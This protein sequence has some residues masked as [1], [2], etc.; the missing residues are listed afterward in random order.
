MKL[1]AF[2]TNYLQLTLEIDK[3]VPGYVDAYLGPAA[4]KA[5]VAATEKREPALLARDLARLQENVPTADPDRAAYLHA[6]L[7]AI[8]GTLQLLGERLAHDAERAQ[9]G[10]ERVADQR[11]PHRAADDHQRRGR[12]G[13]HHR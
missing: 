13:E 2:G 12:V 5:S 1:D 6:M 9:D 8:G 4:L 10:P 11:G 3:H 7:R